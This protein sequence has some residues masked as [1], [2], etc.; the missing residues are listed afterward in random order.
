MK[1]LDCPPG[2]AASDKHMIDAQIEV[3][4]RRIAT[5]NVN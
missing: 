3:F 1:K 5:T 4:R 2:V